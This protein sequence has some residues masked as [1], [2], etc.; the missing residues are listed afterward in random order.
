[1]LSSETSSAS[2][3]LTRKS[4]SRFS[5]SLSGADGSSSGVE[6]I[7]MRSLTIRLMNDKGVTILSPTT[8]VVRVRPTGVGSNEATDL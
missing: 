2:F 1:M 7:G 4:C 5:V 6:S 8:T 3:L